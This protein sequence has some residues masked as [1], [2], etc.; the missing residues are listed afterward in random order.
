M[1]EAYLKMT[2]KDIKDIALKFFQGKTTQEEEELLHQWYEAKDIPKERMVIHME[3]ESKGNV[4]ERLFVSIEARMK[5]ENPYG[6]IRLL[7]KNRWVSIIAATLLLFLSIGIYLYSYKQTE[8]PIH[9]TK[10]LEGDVG[11]GGNNAILE[12]EDGSIINLDAAAIGKLGS[13]DG[14]SVSKRSDG[15]LSIDISRA[16]SNSVAKVNTIKTPPGGQYQVNLP[17]GTKIWLNASSSIAFPSAFVDDHREVKLTGEA[18]FEVA[19]VHKGNKNTPFIVL[20]K[21]QR[22]EVLGT[23]FNV[24]DYPGED[25]KTTLIEG[26]VRVHS[27]V[28]NSSHLL[29]PGQQSQVINGAIEVTTA[30]LESSLSWKNGDFIFNNEELATIMNKLERWYDVEV[31]YNSSVVPTRFSGAVSRSKNL[32]EVL[33]IMELTGKVAFKIEGRRVMVMM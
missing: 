17:D 8:Q 3:N 27:V 15:V 9:Y 4:K 28:S 5:S 13:I 26:S 10:L 11:P 7:S 30:D 22:I 1:V 21:D 20:N 2:E 29:K 33:K 19:K 24:Y 23:H 25:I 18:F 31:E 6:S 32:S 12:L 14:M 16:N